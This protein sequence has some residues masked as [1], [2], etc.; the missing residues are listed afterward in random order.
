MSDATEREPRPMT[1]RPQVRDLLFT[2]N[3]VVDAPRL[4]DWDAETVAAVLEGAGSFAASVLAP[5]NRVGDQQGARFENGVVRAAPGFADA[6]RAYVAGGWNGLAAAEEHGGQGLPKTVDCAVFEIMSAA[7]LAFGLCPML[8]AAGVEALTAFGT[9]DQKARYLSKMVSGE[10]SGTMQLTEPQAG[11]DL[12]AIRT[13]AEPDGEGAYALHGSKIYI[14]WGDHDAADNIVHLVLAR[15]PDAPAGT[16]GIS[17]FVSSKRRVNSDGSLGEHEAV[18]PV[19]L[20]HKLGIHASPTCTMAFE[21]ARAELVGRPNEGL[22]HMFVMMN[23]ARLNVGVQGVAIAERAYQQALAYALERRQGRTALAESGS[24]FDHPDVRGT[25]GL[26]KARIEA[27]RAICLATAVAADL[28][29]H[30]PDE[31]ARRAAR[32]REELLTP[33]AK[34]WSTDMGVAVASDGIQVHGGM[35]FI[36][37]TG[38]AQ[39]YRDARITPIYEG[40]N[41]IQA[42]D[43]ANRKLGLGDGAALAALVADIRETAATH[44]DEEALGSIAGRVSE[45]ADAVEAAAAWLYDRRG[46]ADGLAGATAFLKL[47]GDVTGGWYLLKGAAASRDPGRLALADL[48]AGQILAGARAGERGRPGRRPAAPADGRGA[49]RRLRCRPRPAPAAA[50][51]WRASTARHTAT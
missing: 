25:L 7:N 17:L 51:G 50:F 13:R 12:A 6:Y 38:A 32:L 42:M 9:D 48:Y 34:A 46:T 14:T 18:R 45:G 21:G 47:V 24:V 20:E 31:P 5:L 3:H 16:K 44:A 36:E 39:H 29:R 2:L 10:W 41:G 43:L 37:E 49:R 4:P 26:M 28:A 15:L 40:A 1:F 19:G 11:T 33:V 27:A 8:T 23:A 30:A 22:A 35:G